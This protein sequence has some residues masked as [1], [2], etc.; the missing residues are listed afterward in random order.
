LDSQVLV[1]LEQ[2]CSSI[3]QENAG[4]RT[5]R[6][7]SSYRHLTCSIVSPIR[8]SALVVDFIEHFT[9]QDLHA[10]RVHFH[11]I[12]ENF[13]YLLVSIVASII[14]C[15]VWYPT[16]LGRLVTISLKGAER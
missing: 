15:N 8:S 16:V 7:R 1:L 13:Y 6:F 4:L 14:V 11:S 10:G 3:E 5:S 12:S 2:A 9:F